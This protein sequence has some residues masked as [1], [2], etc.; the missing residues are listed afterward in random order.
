MKQIVL[1]FEKKDIKVVW[2]FILLSVGILLFVTVCKFYFYT[3][4]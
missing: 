4:S 3:Y 1:L 2:K